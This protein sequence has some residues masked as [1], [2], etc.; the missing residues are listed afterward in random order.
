MAENV[1]S[2]QDVME[3]L[4]DPSGERRS[5][6]AQK[7]AVEFDRGALSDAERKLAEE[8]FR[9]MV[10]DAEVRVREALADNLKSN[11]LLPHEVAVALA[12]DVN[13]VALPVL[14]FSEVLTDE[15]LIEIISLQDGDKQSAIAGRQNVSERV[16]DAIVDTGNETAVTRLVSNPGADIS[17]GAFG[18]VVDSMGGSETVQRAMAGRSQLPVTIAERL[19]TLMADSLKAQ[20]SERV[21]L[22]EDAMTD[23]VLQIRE[24][25]VLSL[26]VQSVS[27]DLQ[28]LVDQL[29]KND[30]LTPSIVL[31]ALVMGD[32]P[33]FEQAMAV[34][35]KVSVDNAR[36]LIHD[37]GKL[38]LQ[39]I[40]T[41]ANLPRSY[42]PAARA[43]IDVA[44]ELEYD[45][46][47]RDRERFSRRMIERVLTQY[48]DLG[49]DFDVE[50]LD[51][52]MT[53]LQ[54]LPVD[55]V[56][57]DGANGG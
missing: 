53:K 51:Y 27:V 45:G 34:L 9:I 52:L 35:A 56:D 17:E 39:A 14:E 1:L 13:S 47:E 49:V 37:G 16:S 41:K 40:F 3:L 12:R 5:E 8:I 23:L 30:R 31:R 4:R 15:D 48:G 6:T 42:F 32:L 44:R 57:T 36:E 55:Q 10:K 26:S 43:A 33:F 25:A 18:R 50:D 54:D 24:R 7:I 19:V 20:I 21:S 11:P 28:R 29:Y 22:P 46:G 38:G 2:H